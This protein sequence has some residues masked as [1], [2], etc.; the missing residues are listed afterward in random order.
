MESLYYFKF[1]VVILSCCLKRKKKEKIIKPRLIF[2]FKCLILMKSIYY[3]YSKIRQLLHVHETGA[4]KF[5]LKVSFK[6]T[7]SGW[8][9]STALLSKRFKIKQCTKLIR[10]AYLCFW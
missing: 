4:L 6:T 5:L 10:L 3:H 7:L 9:S 8:L 2:F 1:C